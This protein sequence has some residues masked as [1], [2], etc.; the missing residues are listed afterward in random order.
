MIRL[1]LTLAILIMPFVTSLSLEFIRVVVGGVELEFWRIWLGMVPGALALVGVLIA[2]AAFVRAVYDL[3]NWQ[4]GLQY[5]WRLLFGGAPLSTSELS[6]TVPANFSPYPFIVVK[7]GRIDERH[8]SSLLARWGGPGTVTVFNDSAVV[9]ERFGRYVRVAGPGSVFLERFERVREVLDL[10]PQE[11]TEMASAITKDGLY[12]RSEVQVRFQLARPT[13]QLTPSTPHVPYPVYKWALMRAAQCHAWRVHLDQDVE[14][15]FRWPERVMGNVGSSLRAIVADY[16]LD[17]LLE[18]YEMDRDPRQEISQKLHHQLNA[19]ARNF[20]AEVLDVRMT[21]LE[22]TREEIKRERIASWQAPRR[23]DARTEIA[24]GEAKV[25]RELGEAR[26]YAHLEIVNALAR[27]F[28]EI[29]EQDLEVA[30][31][32]VMMRIVNTLR[33]IW[34]QPNGAFISS[35]ALHTLQY[36]EERAHLQHALPEKDEDLE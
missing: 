1:F 27:A 20:G 14:G 35:Q 34:K 6:G 36:L 28:Q 13:A 26:A 16:S 21:A 17:E 25:I 10:R 22:P 30:S 9:L 32:F 23:R 5:A 8:E 18:P 19:S 31:D 29:S 15:E 4:E 2:G 11:R 12:V 7:E 33:E 24:K 3:A